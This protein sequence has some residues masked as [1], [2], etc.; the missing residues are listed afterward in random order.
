MV[1]RFFIS[2]VRKQ[3]KIIINDI[4]KYFKIIFQKHRSPIKYGLYGVK[5][6]RPYVL[7]KNFNFTNAARSVELPRYLLLA[8]L[9]LKNYIFPDRFSL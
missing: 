1:K 4:Y 2:S 3:I 8:L 9:D 5:L 6:V 7:G